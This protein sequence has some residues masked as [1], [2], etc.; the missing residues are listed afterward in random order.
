MCK[1]SII[2]SEYQVREVLDGKMLRIIRPFRKQPNRVWAE[3]SHETSPVKFYSPMYNG[4]D[5][6]LN[7]GYSD[8]EK[9]FVVKNLKF[10]YG[11][12]GDLLFV[13][14][15]WKVQSWNENE[16][17]IKVAYKSDG[18]VSQEWIEVK[19]EDTFNSLWIESSDDAEEAGVKPNGEGRY[20]WSSG[21][22][23]CRWRSAL[24]MPVSFCRLVLRVSKSYGFFIRDAAGSEDLFED[25]LKTNVFDNS[26]TVSGTCIWDTCFG[27]KDGLSQNPFVHATEFF[28][29][30][31]L[32]VKG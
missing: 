26:Y 30:S 9:N 31:N 20:H 11:G 5:W 15:R 32:S 22:S 25:W 16:G 27:K 14:E 7:V 23:P 19:D 6:L 2:L 21:I 29:E 12:A 3:Q 28:V 17:L 1:H 13:R 18:G 10:P 8:S 24:T 4:K